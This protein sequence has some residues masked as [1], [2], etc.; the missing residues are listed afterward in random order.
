[1]CLL[2]FY[3]RFLAKTFKYI[4]YYKGVCGVK[5]FREI[6]RKYSKSRAVMVFLVAF[7]FVLGATYW[8]VAARAAATRCYVTPNGAGSKTGAS[9]ANAMSGADFANKLRQITS[10]DS[11]IYEF[12]VAK[13][14]YYATTSAD[15]TESFMVKSGVSLYGGFAGN[16]TSL[17]AANPDANVTIL[18][19]N[20]GYKTSSADNTYSIISVDASGS[21]PIVI[22]GFTIQNGRGYNDS[23]YSYHDNAGGAGICTS[24]DKTKITISTCKFIKNCSAA[25]GAIFN[26]TSMDITNCKFTGNKVESYGYSYVDANGNSDAGYGG[27]AIYNSRGRIKV[28]NTTFLDNYISYIQHNS[29]GGGAICNDYGS[30]DIT[31]CTFTKN[32]VSATLP[33]IQTSSSSSYSFKRCYG[34]AVFNLTSDVTIKNSTFNGNSSTYGGGAV[35]SYGGFDD[36]PSSVYVY[37]T[38]SVT[39]STFIN[40]KAGLPGFDNSSSRGMWGGAIYCDTVKSVSAKN[41]TFTGNYAGR[42]EGAVYLSYTKSSDITDCTFKSNYAEQHAGAVGIEF[43]TYDTSY[44]HFGECIAKVTNCTFDSNTAGLRSAGGLYVDHVTADVSGCTFKNNST[45]RSGGGLAFENDVYGTLTNCTFTGN[46]AGRGGSAAAVWNSSADIVNCTFANNNSTRS[47]RYGGVTNMSALMANDAM[48][49]EYTRDTTTLNIINCIFWNNKET[50]DGAT[51]TREINYAFEDSNSSMTLKNCVAE[52]GSISGTNYDNG[53]VITSSDIFTTDPKL[54]ALASNGGPT[55]T[56]AIASG[57]SA[58]NAG[59]S[60]FTGVTIPTVDQRGVSRTAYGKVDIGAYEI[61]VAPPKATAIAINGATSVRVGKN[62]TL[63]AG[64]TPTTASGSLTWSS[65]NTSVAAIASYGDT[66]CYVIGKAAGTA[67]ITAAAKDGSGIKATKTVTVTTAAVTGITI[68]GA[69]SVAV[70]KNIAVTAVITPTNASNALTWSSSNTSVAVVSSYGDTKCYVIGKAAGMAVIIATAKDGSGT[71]GYIAVTVTASGTA[72]SARTSAPASLTL[73]SGTNAKLSET[74]TSLTVK[75]A[76][77]Q[78]SITSDKLQTIGG[79]LYLKDEIVQSAAKASGTSYTDIFTLPIF[80]ITDTSIKSGDI[81]AAEF[82][83]SG[84]KFSSTAIS[85]DKAQIL[86]VFP[87]GTGKL[88]SYTKDL[89]NAKDKTFTILDAENNIVTN[90]E[91]Q[92]TYKLVLFVSDNGAFDLDKEDEGTIVDPAAVLAVGISNKASSGSDSG[93][94]SGSCNAGFGAMALLTLIPLTWRRKK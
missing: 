51:Y 64:I 18:D 6:L 7:I 9:W 8:Y 4:N 45:D 36:Y 66:A 28:S 27:G 26:S 93:S 79:Q 86:K 23:G 53:A 54:S 92:K 12:W 59:L 29:K 32:W 90:I 21:N 47:V 84:D 20:I 39:G 56:M 63:T 80:K 60:S 44:A 72:S 11:N 82:E 87:D 22:N 2:Y 91:P 61:A 34:G 46:S 14:T 69:T 10:A 43:D 77:I 89:T 37:G 52:A 49:N 48:D 30:A 55:Q 41:C 35:Y 70:G 88:F 15:M 1:V 40:N 25:G 24:G 3:T 67:V 42:C 5:D 57:G 33:R 17:S 83:V 58:C 78:K 71:V 85:A 19:G 38:L 73:P 65:S 74:N 75:D 16:E 76:A 68:N 13:G 62:I 50:M 31:D 81:A 94:S